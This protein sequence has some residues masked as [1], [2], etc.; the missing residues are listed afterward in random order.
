MKISDILDQKIGAYVNLKYTETFCIILRNINNIIRQEEKNKPYE[1]IFNKFYKENN[2][3][4]QNSM[5]E[6][7]D[8]YFSIIKKSMFTKEKCLN[9]ILSKMEIS[10]L[11]R[12]SK[13]IRN[14]CHLFAKQYNK[15]ES[16]IIEKYIKLCYKKI[17]KIKEEESEKKEIE[18]QKNKKFKIRKQKTMIEKEGESDE[19]E[20]GE[21]EKMI[22]LFIGKL[23]FKH[24]SGKIQI[25][26]IKRANF[27]N[28]FLFR[29][30]DENNS[31]EDDSNQKL[32]TFKSP[33]PH[34]KD[35]LIRAEKKEKRKHL[36][37]DKKSFKK[38]FFNETSRNN[39]IHSINKDYSYTINKT[40]PTENSLSVEKNDYKNK[41]KVQMYQNN[42]LN[43]EKNYNKIS[44]SKNH[45]F[46]KINIS[47][48]INYL[49]SIENKKQSQ[50]K[51]SKKPFKFDYFSKTDMYY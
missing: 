18:N 11:K 35:K 39:I 16:Y 10:Y 40:L 21:H 38:K 29:N 33:T 23:D 7:I 46:D 26:T 27:V 45:T 44:L 3:N 42:I 41:N 4:N 49:P 36:F 48:T 1:T 20:I 9:I 8:K 51:L 37:I 2:F 43:K 15:N 31:N 28:G 6:K 30:I 13:I 47:K 34:Y 50:I 24:Y 32:L 5:K 25:I 14:K 12:K 19:E 17:K 22:N